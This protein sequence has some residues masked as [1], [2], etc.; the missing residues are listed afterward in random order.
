MFA[1]EAVV[2]D[3]DTVTVCEVA[4][5]VIVP[6]PEVKLHEYEYPPEPPVGLAVMAA[7]AEQEVDG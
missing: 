3:S 5:E 2:P 7:E 4:P 6:A 1:G